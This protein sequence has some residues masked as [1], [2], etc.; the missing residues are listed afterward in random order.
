[1]VEYKYVGVD[2][3][4]GK[5]VAYVGARFTLETTMKNREDVLA[6]LSDLMLRSEKNF[7]WAQVEERK[8][9]HDPRD[10]VFV[11]YIS[12]R[13]AL[14]GLTDEELVRGGAERD[15]IGEWRM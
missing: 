9:E 6:F 2:S 8:M 15:K 12:F 13:I 1:M 10:G 11:E 7:I 5:G 3:A 4:Y 14:R